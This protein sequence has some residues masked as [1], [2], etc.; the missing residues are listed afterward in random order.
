MVCAIAT[1]IPFVTSHVSWQCVATCAFAF[2]VCIYAP[3]NFGP[4]INISLNG[5]TSLYLR[6]YRIYTYDCELEVLWDIVRPNCENEE[7]TVVNDTYHYGRRDT[8]ADRGLSF[9]GFCHRI[10]DC[11]LRLT[12]TPTDMRYNGV[13]ITGVVSLPECFNNSN[14]TNT[15]TLRIQGNRL[16]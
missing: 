2:Q 12:V 7:Y 11:Y 16:V 14:T 6:I 15:T 5:S 13:Q 9:G 8:L 1:V 3:G 4:S 10:I